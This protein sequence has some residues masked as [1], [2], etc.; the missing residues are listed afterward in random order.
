MTVAYPTLPRQPPAHANISL[1]AVPIRARRALFKGPSPT[2]E[3]NK[4][5]S[6]YLYVSGRAG[7]SER[8]RDAR[9]D[10]DPR[11]ARPS[12]A[13]HILAHSRR[14]FNARRR[15]AEVT[16]REAPIH[17]PRRRAL[18]TH[19]RQLYTSPPTGSGLL[20]ADRG[21]CRSRQNSWRRRAWSAAAPSPAIRIPSRI[22]GSLAR[23]TVVIVIFYYLFTNY[24]L[25]FGGCRSVGS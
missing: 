15:R 1:T 20:V 19:P 11:P 18:S 17:T 22:S 2:P 6:K 5:P 8:A 21:P 13:L 9:P 25:P 12:P 4:H 24:Y 10:P 3:T 23:G 14:A 7:A 16:E